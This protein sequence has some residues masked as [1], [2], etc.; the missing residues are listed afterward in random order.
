M[1]DDQPY[2][3]KLIKLVMSHPNFNEIFIDEWNKIFPNGFEDS[4]NKIYD[5]IEKSGNLE[6]W[7]STISKSMKILEEGFIDG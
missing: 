7:K 4:M 1:F 2:T 3:Q 5:V 6:Q